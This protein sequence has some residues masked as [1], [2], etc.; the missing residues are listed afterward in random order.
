MK[1]EKTTGKAGNA[2]KAKTAKVR[3]ASV[4]LLIL[5]AA[6]LLLFLTVPPLFIFWV[7]GGFGEAGKESIFPATELL[8]YAGTIIGILGSVFTASYA[9]LHEREMRRQEQ[10][11]ADRRYR[12]EREDAE[13]KHRTEIQPVLEI[14]LEA[15]E[16]SY[17]ITVTNHKD[18]PAFTVC[19]SDQL[20]FP[21]VRGNQT[22][23]RKVEFEPTDDAEALYLYS[24][25]SQTFDDGMYP[26]T[27]N[28]YYQDKE[29]NSL[30][31]VYIHSGEGSY[32]PNDA[33]CYLN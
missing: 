22:Y 7:Y 9:L 3:K 18:L 10:L 5:F 6:L 14:G 30:D 29:R 16:D 33:G 2:K 13:L 28:L 21:V 24:F 23:R 17:W 4:R 8:G 26:H 25:D 20:I 32:S 11:E 1:N 15:D 12:E 19:I 31:H 27:I